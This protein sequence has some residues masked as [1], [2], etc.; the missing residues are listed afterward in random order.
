M[1]STGT[2][3]IIIHEVQFSKEFQCDQVVTNY[4]GLL[5]WFASNGKITTSSSKLIIVIEYI[6]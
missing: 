1:D 2:Q 6:K 5:V 3:G 4:V